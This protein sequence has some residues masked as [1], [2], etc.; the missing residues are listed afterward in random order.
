MVPQ[1]E[2]KTK[3]AI[4]GMSCVYPDAPGVNELWENIL[5]Q[6]VSFRQ[7]PAK[8]LNEEYFNLKND[9]EDKIYSSK[10]AFIKDYSFDRA[11]FNISKSNYE[12]ADLTHWLTLETTDNALNDAGL[13][14]LLTVDLKKEVG[15]IIGN[16]LTGEQT[17]SNLLRLRWP[18]VANVLKTTLKQEQLKDDEINRILARS[19]KL[20]KS[21]FADFKEDSLAGGLANTIAG[22]ICNY[23]DFKGGGY[24]IDGACSSSLLS[25]IKGCESILQK[26]LKI[27]IVGGVDVSLDPFELVGFSRTE[28]LA[29]SKM[30]VYDEH[31]NGFWPGEGCGILIL[32]DYEFAVQ[33]NLNILASIIGWG[34]SSDGKG[35]IT[36]PE[37][38]GQKLAL[39][40]AAEKAK[41]S[42]SDLDYIEGHGTGT[43]KG[44]ETELTAVQEMLS[45]TDHKNNHK[46][47]I[48]SIKANIGHTKAAA[49]VAGLIKAVCVARNKVIPP[50]SSNH[51]PHAIFKQ[52][53]QLILPD[54]QIILNKKPSLKVGVSSMGFGGINTHVI[55]E[56]DNTSAV[57]PYDNNRQINHK[58]FDAELFAFAESSIEKLQEKLETVTARCNNLS[59][60]EFSDLSC[61][62]IKL[63]SYKKYRASVVARNVEELKEKLI[64][65]KKNI[66]ENTP[67]KDIERGIYYSADQKKVR[68]GLLF[69]G[70]GNKFMDIYSN[71]RV[72]YPSVFSKIPGLINHT[73]SSISTAT[74][75]P[76]L[77]NTACL[78]MDILEEY[79]I[80]AQTAV[81][82]SVGELACL[83]FSK[84]LSYHQTIELAA[85]RGQLMEESKAVKGSML[86]V[87]PVEDE[88]YCLK[89][90]SAAELS[91]ACINSSEQWVISG[92]SEQIE[93]LHADLKIKGFACLKLNVENAFHSELM[94]DVESAFDTYLKTVPFQ[95]K[96]RYYYS[97]VTAEKVKENESVKELLLTQLTSP[98]LFKDTV[99]KANKEVDLW[100][101]A[102]AADSLKKLLASNN[103]ENAISLGLQGDSIWDLSN[104]L[105]YL[106]SFDNTFKIEHHISRRVFKMVDLDVENT[107]I[108]NPCENIDSFGEEKENV[109]EEIEEIQ[110]EETINVVSELVSNQNLH[111]L[112]KE[113]LAKALELEADR[114]KDDS[115]LLDDY[116]L[117]S[118]YVVQFITSFAKKNDLK[119][120]NTLL[121]Y[122]NASVQDIVK[123]FLQYNF[124]DQF[125]GKD[126][127]MELK[128]TWIK[129]FVKKWCRE[130]AITAERKFM[131]AMEEGKCFTYNTYDDLL[132]VRYTARQYSHWLNDLLELKKI[133]DHHLLSKK[134]VFVY[135]KDYF[136]SFLKSLLKENLL[137]KLLLIYEND[138]AFAEDDFYVQ[139]LNGDP[140]QEVKIEKENIY[141]PEFEYDYS[142][143]ETDVNAVVKGT[144]LVSGG[145]KGIA[146]EAIRR[147]SY[148][149]DID[150]LIIG[151]ADRDKDPALKYNLELLEKTKISYNYLSIDLT[152][153][154][155]ILK[156]KE[157]IGSNKVDI[158][159]FIHSAGYNNPQKFELITKDSLEAT[160]NPKVA[161]FNNVFGIIP[162]ES[163]RFVFTFGS[164]IG[165]VG[166]EGNAEY[167]FANQC[168]RNTVEEL[169]VQNDHIRFLNFEWSVWDEVGMGHDLGLLELLKLNGVIPINI[170]TGSEILLNALVAK[171]VE[172]SLFVSGKFPE[173][174]R[175]S[176]DVVA[177]QYR[178][179]EDIIENIRGVEF[180]SEVN[181]S[182]VT[183]RYLLDHVVDNNILFPGVM[184]VEA[185]LQSFDVFTNRQCKLSHLRLRNIEFQN[186]II[187]QDATQEIKLRIVIERQWASIYSVSILSGVNNFSVKHF[188]YE[189]EVLPENNIPFFE[190]MP[191]LKPMGL[192]H[193]Y[194]HLLFHGSSFQ[195]VE[196]FEFLRYDKMVASVK[197]NVTNDVFNQYM[198]NGLMGV[199]PYIM[200]ALLHSIQICVPHQRLLPVS[201][202]SVN[203]HLDEISG[204]QLLRIKAIEHYNDGVVYNYTIQLIDAD[205]RC[206]VNLEGV[207]FKRVESIKDV[208]Y[209]PEQTAIIVNRFLAEN[210]SLKNAEYNLVFEPLDFLTYKRIDGKPFLDEQEFVSKSD[211]GTVQSAIIASERV[212]LDIEMVKPSNESRWKNVLRTPQYELA[213]YLSKELKEDINVSATRI[214][215]AI[216]CV[217]KIGH[218]ESGDV[219][220]TKTH[221][222]GFLELQVNGH[223]IYNTCISIIGDDAISN[224]YSISIIR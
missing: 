30:L 131:S 191:D 112:F 96:D 205:N 37:K 209:T 57:N 124:D 71:L 23:Y 76:A 93:S 92:K 46:T 14:D 113:E 202:D 143:E 20:Y 199:N 27:A 173:L 61:T 69:P 43:K 48:G 68:T 83:Y 12:T 137:G 141:I 109:S 121:E 114:I 73:T 99:E 196:Q 13:K 31:S 105:A 214:W 166:M 32:A 25:V 213:E 77:V 22:R 60:A 115:R 183:D 144:I 41:I 5:Q 91:I 110:E 184:G 197:P 182:P 147:M 49:G 103:I 62:L 26:D 29:K 79:G 104:V 55:V 86:L 211:S 132:I 82:H 179:V 127:G 222:S 161:G 178:F 207:S 18:Y 216:E 171:N 200:D 64:F 59:F 80:Y 134:L 70:Q 187:L 218:L 89:K 28:A 56:G 208:S 44:D 165:N 72:I 135:D 39:K 81:G 168:L 154:E 54:Q 189:I 3:V 206:L 223:E 198:G 219:F 128:S 107:Y 17:R 138:A 163:L 2:D 63:Y 21:A 190:E 16:T 152:K 106:I 172:T 75:Q 9:P 220:L 180:V 84:S 51:T 157:Y 8:R 74:A 139:L 145:G 150:F 170:D 38:D 125:E 195:V 129:T 118:L 95:E 116:H 123:M 4:I 148:R 164:V 119:V 120:S 212:G 98:V 66:K 6:R 194:D 140:L 94:K 146:F 34:I 10:G 19:K 52:N 193:V 136:S 153:E 50:A 53:E 11:R 188:T 78:G 203:Y 90:I 88:A 33:N 97:T 201:I 67:F 58:F 160:F 175:K 100:I 40:R 7:F 204:E 108:I 142:L 1:K 174:R 159:G 47:Y 215:T 181:I 176:N 186:P 101:E 24:T 167:A 15:V 45:E 35:G 156:L 65:L 149:H 130:G 117:N 177:H 42:F 185:G 169:K 217:R 224:I 133:L 87:N 85:F 210:K 36:R 162:K 122:S 155:D 111:R 151:R 221:S 192:Q 126:A 158:T 102:G